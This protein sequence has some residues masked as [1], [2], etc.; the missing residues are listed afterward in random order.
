MPPT[1]A[2]RE[3]GGAPR[4]PSRHHGRPRARPPG[5]GEG[6]NSGKDGRAPPKHEF[7]KVLLVPKRCYTYPFGLYY[8][9]SLVASKLQTLLRY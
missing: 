3:G 5:L 6:A 8:S 2:A 1:R 4:R 7:S 9:L